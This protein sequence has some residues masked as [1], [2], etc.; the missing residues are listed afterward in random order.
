[1]IFFMLLASNNLVLLHVMLIL[2]KTYFDFFRCLILQTFDD[3]IFVLVVSSVPTAAFT[4]SY[5]MRLTPSVSSVAA[6]QAA[7]VSMTL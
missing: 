2:A 1:M 5:L 6:W 4:S 7:Q 3:F